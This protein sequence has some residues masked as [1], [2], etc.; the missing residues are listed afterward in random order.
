MVKISKR[1][2]QIG[3]SQTVALNSVM[4]QMKREGK[5]VVGLGAGEPDFDTPAHI[6]NAAIEAIQAGF[7]KYTPADGIM[8]LRESIC[9]WLK[10]ERHIVYTPKEVIVTC[11]AKH[12]VYQ[13]I[14]AVCD[15]GE[16]VLLPVPYWVSYPEQIKLSGAE[17]VPMETTLKNDLKIT[18]AQLEKAIDKKTRLLILNS[19]SNPSGA[20]YDAD[21]LAAIVRVVRESGIYLLADEIYDQIIYDGIE[22]A[23][24][25]RFADIKDQLLYVNG[26]SKSY[27]MTG[28][29]IGYLVANQDI[30]T[31]IKKYQG[32][33]TSNP[34]SISQKAALAGYAGQKD[35]LR[36][37]NR[38]FAERRDY[39]NE[40]LNAIEGVS[41]LK[42]QGA[43]YAFPDFSYYLNRSKNGQEIKSSF[44]LCGYLL[45]NYSVAIVPGAAF[46]MD[47]Y[48]RLSFATSMDILK[49]AL[50]RIE[51]GL[52][53]L[54]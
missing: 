31:A 49:K 41:C 16:K 8:E 17:M 37:M 38:A 35:F 20:V 11:G 27:A 45:K 48:A 51:A 44:D 33:S 3:E 32:H 46:G 43:F 47:S 10:N 6:K 54:L 24:A 52:L 12:A 14:C 7:T 50:D 29:R 2:S 53:S 18:A 25:T 30:I 40:R 23:S 1:F 13:A 15:E 28:W 22:Y 9:T 34:A 19:P 4:A 26:V 5:D 36:D 39:V 21:E 42:P